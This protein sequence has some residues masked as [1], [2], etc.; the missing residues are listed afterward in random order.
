MQKPLPVG[1]SG[2]TQL[3]LRSRRL[4][5]SSVVSGAGISLSVLLTG[6]EKAPAAL[7]KAVTVATVSEDTAQAD[8]F[9]S[10][11]GVTSVSLFS[12]TT[13]LGASAQPRLT[14]AVKPRLRSF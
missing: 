12:S 7:D 10:Q 9:S 5:I 11:S 4:A 6:T 3:E 8:I 2:R 13:S 1:T 14:V